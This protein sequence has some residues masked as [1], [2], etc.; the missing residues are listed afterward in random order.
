MEK[1]R[2]RWGPRQSFRKRDAKAYRKAE[3]SKNDFNSCTDKEHLQRVD[4]FR[5]LA[6]NSDSPRKSFGNVPMA[7]QNTTRYIIG[8]RL[9]QGGDLVQRNGLSG[10]KSDKNENQSGFIPMD[11]KGTMEGKHT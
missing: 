5:Q 7:P 3:L 8:E 6:R 9:S 11:V 4:R 10:T 1:S 2:N